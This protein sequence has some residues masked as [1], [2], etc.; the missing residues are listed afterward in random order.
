MGWGRKAREASRRWWRQE[1]GHMG[2][3]FHHPYVLT[4]P[5]HA[6]LSLL[7][8]SRSFNSII[9]HHR[10]GYMKIIENGLLHGIV[11]TH[12][13]DSSII[14]HKGIMNGRVLF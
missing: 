5:P 1:E 8:I 4:H 9:T 3:G 11:K 7:V 14:L 13:M 6:P 10:V 2:S 12:L